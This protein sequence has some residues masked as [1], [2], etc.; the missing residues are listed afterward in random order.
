VTTL[1]LHILTLLGDPNLIDFKH[2]GMQ[3][4]H[5][6]GLV[7]L[8]FSGTILAVMLLLGMTT[9]EPMFRH[10][11]ASFVGSSVHM[12]VLSSIL[13]VLGEIYEVLKGTNDQ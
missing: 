1:V 7:V 5:G 8:M 9:D 3:F 11:Y 10:Q 6:I 4:C 2:L 12:A 13:L